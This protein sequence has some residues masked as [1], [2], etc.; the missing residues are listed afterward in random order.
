MLAYRLASEL[1][2]RIAAIAAVAGTMGTETCHPSRPV[3]ILHF[4]GTADEHLPFGGGRGP[5]TSP[6]NTFISVP[7]SLSAWVRANGCPDTPVITH[8][9]DAAADGM[10]VERHVYG[11]GQD[12]A[13]VVLYKVLGGGHTWPGRTARERLLGPTTQDIS[14]NDLM[15]E[16]FQ[17]HARP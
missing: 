15:W 10:T 17:R 8:M 13:E 2:D 16:F 11:P 7:H 6:G 5:R 14:A 12:G 9:P 4:H 1:S 3:S